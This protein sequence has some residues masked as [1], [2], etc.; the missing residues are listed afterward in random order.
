MVIQ[1]AVVVHE[2]FRRSIVVSGF[3]FEGVLQQVISFKNLKPSCQ[4]R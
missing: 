3:V 2:S 4:I 1:I